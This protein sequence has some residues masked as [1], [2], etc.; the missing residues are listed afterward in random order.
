MA[1]QKIYTA[2]TLVVPLTSDDEILFMNNRLS[3][4]PASFAYI[5]LPSLAMI[6][7]TQ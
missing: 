7:G 3:G 1:A 2:D 6:G 5:Y 4:A